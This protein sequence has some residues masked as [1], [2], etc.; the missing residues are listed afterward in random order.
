MNKLVYLVYPALV[1]LLVVGMKI[2]KKGE[3]NEEF[4]SLRQTK[5]LQGFTALLIMCHH[6]G[7][8]TCAPWHEMYV[9]V[10][11]LDLFV[12]YGF[13]FV[14][15]FLFC[16]GYGLYKSY[17]SKE[18]YFKGFFKKRVLP[19]IVTFYAAEY[20]F[21]VVRYLLGEN[22]DTRKLIL[23]LIGFRFANPNSWYLIAAP[24]FY[25]IFYLCFKFI[26]NEKTAT[27]VTSLCIVAYIIGGTFIRHNP[28]W[29]CG[30]WWYQ[31]A[32][33]FICGLLFAHN[34]KKIIAHVKKNYIAYLIISFVLIFILNFVAGI[35]NNKFS[36]YYGEYSYMKVPL[37]SMVWRKWVTLI[38]HILASASFI[39]FIFIAMLKVK[40]GNAVL[41]FMGTITME[42]YIIHG[43]FVE[44][45]GYSFDDMLRSIV[46]VRNPALHFVI[47]LAGSIP[48]ALLLKMFVDL[49][50]QRN[51]KPKKI[52]NQVN[53]EI[54]E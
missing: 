42:F 25:L 29:M 8:K 13:Y 53:K 23:Y 46:Y 50:T 28:Y 39:F 14:G 51:K 11:G 36:Y 10:H 44:L 19:I 4:M 48:S 32:P 1:A 18:N 38:G 21:I 47:V 41:G 43:L 15:I 30:E 5:F 49:V 37:F 27:L 22:I 40:I 35:L 52:K 20:I 17:K 26:K 33:M 54:S 7:Q 31:S 24:L 34:D 9:I 3:W 45:F 2:S 16:S 6:L 12:D